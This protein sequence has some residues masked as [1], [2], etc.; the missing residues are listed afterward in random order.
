MRIKASMLTVAGAVAG[1]VTAIA[2]Y[3]SATGA[4]AAANVSQVST[5]PAA[6]ASATWL[7]CAKGWKLKGEACVRIKEKVVVVHDLPAPFAGSSAAT[8]SARPTYRSSE[9]P[10]GRET[11]GPTATPSPTTPS[12]TPTTYHEVEP[13]DAPD[14]GSTSTGGGD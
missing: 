9:T 1:V 8:T 6:H 13:S 4:S 5:T 14:T 7:P 10:S 2:A 3:Q 12:S 11:S